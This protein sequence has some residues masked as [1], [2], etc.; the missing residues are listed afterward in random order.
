MREIVLDPATE[1]LSDR[2]EALL[3][4]ADRA[5]HVDTVVRPALE[6]GAVV[7]TDRYV[8]SS[9]AYQGAGRALS[10]EEVARVSAWATGGLVPNLTVV[11]D[12]DPEVGLARSSEPADRLEAEPLDFHRR[13]REAF[14]SAA[15]H[16]PGR[17][18]VVDATLPPDEVAAR[19]RA[20]LDDAIPL[21]AKE[22]EA[23]EEAARRWAE[24]EEQRRAEEAAPACRRGG[25]QAA[26]GGAGTAARRGG[27]AAARGGGGP[28]G[29]AARGRGT[30]AGRDRGAARRRGG[31]SPAGGRGGG[32]AAGGGGGSPARRRGGGPAAGGGGGGPAARGGGGA[33]GGRGAGPPAWRPRPRPAASPRSWPG[34]EPTRTHGAGA[35]ADT[36]AAGARSPT[37]PTAVRRRAGRG[38]A[39][40]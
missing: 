2:A 10:A 27:G 31:G 23:A 34:A 26:R 28:P 8:D 5:Q 4:A 17:Y 38:P 19:L 6:R 24:E 20:R 9:V 35:A 1:G 40:A 3:Y 37:R 36:A 22:R 16:E 14:L 29:G 12:I 33:Q 39:D 32:P 15:A 7:V 13:V 30:A 18:L 11:L 21:S 25:G